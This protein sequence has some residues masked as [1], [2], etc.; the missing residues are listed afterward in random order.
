[1]SKNDFL[2]AYRN[3]LIARYTWA[4]DSAR[5][6]RF[7]ESVRITIMTA[8]TT[9]NHEGDA[10]VAAWLTVPGKKGKPTLKG[11]RALSE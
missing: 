1:M 9:W 8:A 4:S 6:D 2:A 11:L 7:M 10:E 5:L 3:E